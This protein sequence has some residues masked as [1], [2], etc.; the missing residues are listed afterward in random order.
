MHA[1][2]LNCFSHVWL[3][4]TLWTI[5]RQ[6]PLSRGFSRQEY[7]SGLL[8]LSPGNLSNTGIEPTSL[9]SPAL[10]GGFFTTGA[11]W[12]AHIICSMIQWVHLFRAPNIYQALTVFQVLILSTRD[13]A[14]NKTESL[15]FMG[16]IFSYLEQ[17]KKQISYINAD[18]R[19]CKKK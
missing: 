13:I 4:A 8:C 1:C 12:E 11:F 16:L 15:A 10:A 14:A 17:D 3:F 2:M 9:K 19:V 6:A 18:A 7:W 5:A